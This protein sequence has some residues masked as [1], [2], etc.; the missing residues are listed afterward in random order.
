[1]STRLTVWLAVW[2]AQIQR[3]VAI[4]SPQDWAV[5]F[6]AFCGA[7]ASDPTVVFCRLTTGVFV[8]FDGVSLKFPM[9]K[10]GS[11][12]TQGFSRVR[13]TW[14]RSGDMRKEPVVLFRLSSNRSYHILAETVLF[15]KL[16]RVCIAT[17][18]SCQQGR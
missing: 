5:V 18:S 7:R 2:A 6:F 13:V 15:T 12:S 1:M 4:L 17:N 9:A 10:G 3:L 16:T 14:A 8:A 11:S